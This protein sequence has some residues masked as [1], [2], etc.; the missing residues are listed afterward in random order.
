MQALLHFWVESV[1]YTNASVL[2]ETHASGSAFLGAVAVPCLSVV[3]GNGVVP[4]QSAFDICAGH[5]GTDL[6][7][8][9]GLASSLLCQQVAAAIVLFADHRQRGS[10]ISM[11]ALP[12]GL[13]R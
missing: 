13:L 11:L 12:F 3:A 2:I 9:N 10:R 6:L 7:L 8:D 1:L 5:A 4:A